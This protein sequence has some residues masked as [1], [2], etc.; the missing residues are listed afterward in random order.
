M[1][2]RR[3]Q[4]ARKPKPQRLLRMRAVRGA[5]VLR[6]EKRIPFEVPCVI[7]VKGVPFDSAQGRLSTAPARTEQASLRMTF[8]FGGKDKTDFMR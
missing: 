7:R 6:F 3:A 8:R 5:D 2:G 4:G 1:L